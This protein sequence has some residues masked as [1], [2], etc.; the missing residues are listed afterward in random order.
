[1]IDM[2]TR[3][4]KHSGSFLDAVLDGY[5]VILVSASEACAFSCSERSS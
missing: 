5:S 2:V 1:M 3:G 4:R